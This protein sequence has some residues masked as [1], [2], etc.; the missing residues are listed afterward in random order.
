MSM[1]KIWMTSAFKGIWT[2]VIWYL[3]DMHNSINT[4]ML[5]LFIV[6]Y[7]GMRIKAWHLLHFMCV[8]PFKKPDWK[9]ESGRVLCGDII[10]S[11]E[12]FIFS[13]QRCHNE[14]VSYLKWFSFYVCCS[15]L[16]NLFRI[17]FIDFELIVGMVFFFAYISVPSI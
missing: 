1:R 2:Y 7:N 11:T 16:H 10:Y 9:K 15:Q 17:R 6:E 14:L 8:R 4:Q 13:C 12:I 3:K 5:I